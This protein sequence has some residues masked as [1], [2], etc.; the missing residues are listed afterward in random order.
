MPPPRRSCS[1]VPFKIG[2]Y[3]RIGADCIVEAASIGM[4]VIIGSGSIVVRGH[5]SSLRLV[6]SRLISEESRVITA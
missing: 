3:V 1:T 4:W 6:V 5:V 2:E